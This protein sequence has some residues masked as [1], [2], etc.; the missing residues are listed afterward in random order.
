MKRGV[1]WALSVILVMAMSSISLAG[2][3]PTTDGSQEQIDITKCVYIGVKQLAMVDKSAEASV[4]K[5]DW[6]HDNEV[7]EIP[8]IIEGNQILEVPDTV[9]PVT[10][11]ALIH[12]SAF[13]DFQGIVTINQ[14]PGNVNNQGNAVSTA[15]ADCGNAFLHAKADVEK[16]LG[17]KYDEDSKTFIGGGNSFEACGTP[18]TDLITDCFIGVHGVFGINQS[19]GN[20]N[21]QNNALAMAVSSGATACLAESDLE[22]INSNNT[23]HE[24]ATIKTDTLE[25]AIFSGTGSSGIVGINQ[26]T[27]NI[28]NQ[29]NVVSSCLLAPF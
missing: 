24:I 2:T 13:N 12:D 5:F 1:F 6:S 10:P 14:S 25:G 26:A 4:E 21:N 23:V 9:I 17:S 11:T 7:K 29:A 27:G 8:E 3:T 22:L 20:I 19:A 15:F 18:R 28:V 16:I